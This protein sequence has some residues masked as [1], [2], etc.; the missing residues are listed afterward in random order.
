MANEQ[1]L[2]YEKLTLG[3]YQTNC[4]VVSNPATGEAVLIDAPG[5]AAEILP[6]L[7]G[8]KVSCVFLTHTHADHTGALA[9]LRQALGIPLAMHG[10]E[11]ARVSPAPERD[12]KDGDLVR[13][14]TIELRVIHTPGHTPGSLCLHYGNHLFSGDTIFPG[15]PGKT[16]SPEEF[17]RVVDS[18]TRRLFRLP[19]G[20]AV[21]PG[22]GEDTVLG[23]EKKEF[24]DFAARPHN[25]DLCGDV[26]WKGS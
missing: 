9:D 12:L 10:T 15:G 8:L 25:R 7:Q 20:T 4:Y 1:P 22:H 3:P 16:K 14:G 11:A 23:K 19:D 6:H 18:I 21:H 5:S 13:L 17:R 2:S 26:T 24:A